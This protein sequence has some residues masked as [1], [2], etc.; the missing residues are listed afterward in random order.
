MPTPAAPTP[1]S[2]DE[3]EDEGG[4]RIVGNCHSFATTLA[5]FGAG[6]APSEGTGDSALQ[7]WEDCDGGEWVAVSKEGWPII[8]RDQGESKQS[9]WTFA[10]LDDPAK[11]VGTWFHDGELRQGVRALSLR[12]D[13]M[14]TESALRIG[15]SVGRYKKNGP[16]IYSDDERKIIELK[17][18]CV[19]GAVIH[20]KEIEM[21][22]GGRHYLTVDA[23]IAGLG[24]LGKIGFDGS[25]KTDFGT[26]DRFCIA[27]VD[28]ILADAWAKGTPERK[29]AA[30]RI[31]ATD[32]RAN[33][34]RRRG[35]KL[36]FQ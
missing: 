21:V 29:A 25:E 24:L 19:F 11:I 4:S 12:C 14:L 30:A 33:L 22:D 5:P 32:Y 13:L 9:T 26:M 23:G 15:M 20:F 16:W 36:R 28:A 8:L 34:T 18:H 10:G 1:P 31:A 35:V 3:T 17:S 27:L 7:Y 6:L 2:A